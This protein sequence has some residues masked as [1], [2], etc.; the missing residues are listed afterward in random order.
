MVSLFATR[1]Q[2]CA[3]SARITLNT[4][5]GTASAGWMSAPA[6]QVAS[7]QITSSPRG[8]KPL[9]EFITL[10]ETLRRVMSLR[11]G[12]VTPVMSLAP[13]RGCDHATA[14]GCYKRSAAHQPGG[15]YAVELLALAVVRLQT[16]RIN[17]DR[18]GW[19]HYR[20][21]FSGYEVVAG[22]QKSSYSPVQ[23]RLAW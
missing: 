13:K 18:M 19:D 5:F 15:Q 12:V 3:S 23:H 9:L 6:A 4:T 10:T 14:H 20:R 16:P 1:R 8:C 7:F 22:R 11:C 17:K 21:P 2:Q